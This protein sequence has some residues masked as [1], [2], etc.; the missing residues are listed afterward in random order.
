MEDLIS[1]KS[2]ENNDE[3]SFQCQIDDDGVLGLMPYIWMTLVN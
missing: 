3:V 1:E 2:K